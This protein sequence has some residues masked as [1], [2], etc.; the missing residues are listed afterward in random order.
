MNGH[1]DET[2]GE[3]LPAG[4]YWVGDLCYV[5]HD[6]WDE[7]CDLLFEGRDDHGCNQ[8][9]FRLKDGRQFAMYNT[10]YGDGEYRDNK[11]L[12]YAVDSGSLGCILLE[13]I[14]ENESNDISL[15][16]IHHFSNSVK[17]GRTEDGTVWFDAGT[18]Q[19]V[20]IH[21]GDQDEEE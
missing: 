9:V 13:N 21:T 11:S 16:N 2:I 10:Q 14:L 4:T 12:K 6:C 5:M 17:N 15:G 20:N 19:Y 1:K 7:V 18:N 8:G 3:S